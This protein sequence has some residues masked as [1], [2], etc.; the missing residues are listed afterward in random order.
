MNPKSNTSDSALGENLEM[1]ERRAVNQ[2]AKSLGETE[3]EALVKDV[4]AGAGIR[5]VRTVQDLLTL[6]EALIGLGGVPAIVGRSL[7]VHAVLKGAR[8]E[9]QIT[10]A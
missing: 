2:L 9:E 7:K 5:R 6:G 8:S 4:L 3:A 10:A 1:Y